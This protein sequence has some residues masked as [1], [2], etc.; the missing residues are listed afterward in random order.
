MNFAIVADF[1]LKSSLRPGF[2]ALR[3]GNRGVPARRAGNPGLRP[4][5]PALRAGNP[6]FPAL[7]AG[8]PGTVVI[9]WRSII[10]CSKQN[11]ISFWVLST[12]HLR[13]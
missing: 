8:N 1:N 12:K 10:T 7:R 11:R 9:D 2:T 5:F 6:G 3:A 13:Y 4:G